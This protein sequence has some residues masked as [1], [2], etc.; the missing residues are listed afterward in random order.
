[1]AV[2]ND[3]S[4]FGAVKDGDRAPVA[5]G[6]DVVVSWVNGHGGDVDTQVRQEHHSRTLVSG[7]ES[8]P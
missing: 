2:L 3:V 5:L 7:Q 4:M 1:M 6:S 8:N